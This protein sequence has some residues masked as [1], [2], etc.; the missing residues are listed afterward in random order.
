MFEQLEPQ[1]KEVSTR[2]NYFIISSV[3]LV[4]ILFSALVISIFMVDLDLSMGD[5][6]MLEL[7]APIDVTD[8][9]MPDLQTAPHSKPSGGATA[10]RTVE[11]ARIDESPREV[12]TTI[13]TDKSTSK[14]RPDA[15][16]FDIGKFDSEAVAGN[17]LGHGTGDGT[18]DG[19]GLGDGLGTDDATAPAKN[20]EAAATPPRVTVPKVVEKPVIQS[21][22]VVNSLAKSL[23]KPMYP[24]AARVAKA[25][26]TV[27][28]Q[29]LVD[30]KGNVVKASAVSG[31]EMLRQACEIAARSARFTPT[32]LSG[33]PIKISGVIN[34]HFNADGTT[35]D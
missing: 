27:T 28:V 1:T 34:Y 2:R 30:E 29:V 19:D 32:L 33:E 21:K 18:G 14:S 22:G 3:G 13:S 26:G 5:G 25:A 6:D 11:M 12:P 24:A 16:R 4:A 20:T 17:G 8:Q 15:S 35:T 23:P 7:L 31:D 9:K 10:T